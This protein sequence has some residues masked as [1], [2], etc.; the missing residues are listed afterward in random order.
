MVSASAGVVMGEG[1]PGGRSEAFQQQ[2][3]AGNPMCK[4]LETSA[5]RALEA[6]SLL[7]PG[8]QLQS[9]R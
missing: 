6:G 1:R 8:A 3:E 7:D 2:R 5:R 9:E 4:D